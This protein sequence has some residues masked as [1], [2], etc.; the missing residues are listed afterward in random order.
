[1]Q[2]SPPV[3]GIEGVPDHLR[4]A[5][6]P[7][8]KRV[9]WW[10]TPEE[11]LDDVIRFTAQ[12]MTFGDFEDIALTIRLLGDSVFRQVLQNPPPGVFDIKSWTFW[13]FHY[14]M[15]VPPLPVRKL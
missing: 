1:M 8:S 5:L 10:G 2:T 6:A 14:H 4:S 7:I 11:W 12:V 9:F 15:P 3:T 13:H